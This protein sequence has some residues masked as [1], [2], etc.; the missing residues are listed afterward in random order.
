[1]IDPEVARLRRLRDA[2]LRSRAIARALLAVRTGPE[3]S[4]LDR[5]ACASWRVARAASGRLSAHPCIT[6]HR[7][8]TLRTLL[9]H[10]L[11]ARHAALLGR[12]R[13][14]G[15][16]ERELSAL[17]RLVD[18][19]RALTLAPDLSETLGRA[20][21]ELTSLRAE[22]GQAIASDSAS[23]RAAI[24]LRAPSRPPLL[25]PVPERAVPAALGADWPYLAL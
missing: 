2:A 3:D 22:L 14:L 5:A 25:A 4:L 20:Q 15:V 16:C 8:P 13:R 19:V 9:E 11:G 21:W 12:R 7:G 10:A 23:P 17:G 24:P 1:M 18:D 6:Y